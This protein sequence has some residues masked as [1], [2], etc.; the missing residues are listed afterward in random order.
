MKVY[1]A[2]LETLLDSG[3]SRFAGMVGS[4][5]APYVA[6]L[7]ASDRA[8]YVGVRHE[9]VAAAMMD[10]TARLTA[11]PGCVL[12]HGA[13][14]ALAASLGIAA[15]A[16]D[17]TPLLLLSATQER[18]AMENEYWQTLDVLTPMSGFAKWQA[19]VERS[20]AAV[21]A[22][23][24]ALHEAVSGRPGVAQ[25]DLPIDVSVDDAPDGSAA[26]PPQEAV[27]PRYRPAPGPEAVEAVRRLLGEADRP[28]LVAGVGVVYSGAG[29]ALRRLA[30]RLDAPVVSSQSA[31]GVFPEDH[32]LS[33][34]VSGI[35]GFE[36]ASAAILEADLVVGIGCRLS[37]MQLARGELLGPRARIVH[38]DIEPSA[39]GRYH[40][41]AVG[42]VA[43]S[44]A[45]LDALETAMDP[46]PSPVPPGRGTWARQA[47]ER[48]RSWKAEWLRDL[49][50]N[51][52][53]QPQEAV[54][55]MCDQLPSDAILTHG[56]GD[57][58]FYGNMV[59]VA[60][61]GRHLV[62]AK[63]G[64]MGCALGY[65]MGARLVAPEQPIVACVGDG[66][67]MLQV[68]DLETMVREDLP[69]IVV[70]FNNF[71][72]GSQRKR[73]ELYGEAFG[74]DHTNPDFARL[75]D[76]FGARGRRVDAPGQFADAFAE[77]L[78]SGEPTVI[79]VLV[80]PDARPPRIA[81]SREAR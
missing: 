4:S 61:P 23:R 52:L 37:D 42:V 35:L 59:P 65:A 15:A 68:G 72:L 19:R 21:P 73:V 25:V 14:G 76:L 80:D 75:A 66:E 40:P 39:I 30:E 11:T 53:V 46:A 9:Q 8:R 28:V 81:I 57:H 55:A 7:G 41:P 2:V 22:V 71:R 50:D 1:E 24:R 51:G 3:V 20:D 44:A 13:S 58:G 48:V 12:T 49:P 31:R 63:L 74:V 33:L 6:A 29:D 43:D 69:A 64:A 79:D 77:A 34:G 18:R 26:E 27:A 17:Y 36:A 32:E 10:A 16:R 56:A 60:A 54:L 78:R 38:V 47:A 62:S 45:F 67:L 5:T 70:V